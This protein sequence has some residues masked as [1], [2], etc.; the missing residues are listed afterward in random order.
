MNI[1]MTESIDKTLIFDAIKNA[2]VNE[3]NNQK[4]DAIDIEKEALELLLES[5]NARPALLADNS[6]ESFQLRI[7][8]GLVIGTSCESVETLNDIPK[9]VELFLAKHTLAKQLMVQNLPELQSLDWDGFETKMELKNEGSVGLSLADYGIAE[10]AS[11]VIRSSPTMPVLLNFLPLYH[12][13]IV[14]KSTILPYMD[15]Y[16]L[17]ANQEAAEGNTPRNICMITG[18]SGTTDIEGVL[19]QGA[20]G[21]EFLHIIIIDEL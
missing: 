6:Y 21:P 4:P 17:L 15:D 2:S 13:V 5:E 12:V 10:T 11:I 3:K 8:T 18:A 7:N 19:V 16:A 14:K 9:A 20:H 1:K